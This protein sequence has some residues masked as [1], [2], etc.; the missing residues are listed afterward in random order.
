MADETPFHEPCAK[1]QDISAYLA[2]AQDNNC[3][4]CF[5][6]GLRKQLEG[7]IEMIE[8]RRQKLLELY[9]IGVNQLSY[10]DDKGMW[11]ACYSVHG[12]VCETDNFKTRREAEDKAIAEYESISETGE[13]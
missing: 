8:E 3:F 12:D 11:F 9:G 10:S 7:G 5:I 6:D 2:R 1:H 4:G 13:K